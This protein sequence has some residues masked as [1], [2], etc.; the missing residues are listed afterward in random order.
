MIRYLELRNAAEP[1]Q[2]RIRV[3]V[4]SGPVIGAV[5]GIKKYI[6]DIFGDTVNTASRMETHSEPMSINVSEATYARTKD[7]FRFVER[8]SLE[9]KSSGIMQMYFLDRS[10]KA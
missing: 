2:W 8:P 7:V 10:E 1:R 3:G 4:H 6:Y 5:V 9:V